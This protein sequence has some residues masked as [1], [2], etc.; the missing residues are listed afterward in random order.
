M[1]YDAV[2]VSLFILIN[3]AI[4]PSSELQVTDFQITNYLKCDKFHTNTPQNIW[5]L[6]EFISF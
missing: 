5:N 3:A 2:S 1:K 4:D 6:E